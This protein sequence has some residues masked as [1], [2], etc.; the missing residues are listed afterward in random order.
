MERFV[1][2]V[3]TVGKYG[4]IIGIMML[5]IAF[6]IDICR[7]ALRL[8]YTSKILAASDAGVDTRKIALQ[9]VWRTVRNTVVVGGAA[10]L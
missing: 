7:E 5:V 2:G 8:K 4:Y 1:M 10:W 3:L 6:S 9:A